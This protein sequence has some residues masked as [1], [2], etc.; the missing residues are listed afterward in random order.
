MFTGRWQTLWILKR[1]LSAFACPHGGE[2]QAN[3]IAIGIGAVQRTFVFVV[4]HDVPICIQ[5]TQLIGF[6]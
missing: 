1:D 3:V 2:I 6:E 4:F 5:L